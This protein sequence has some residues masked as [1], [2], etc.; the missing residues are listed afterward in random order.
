MVTV[1]EGG[2]YMVETL[3]IMRRKDMFVP[4]SQKMKK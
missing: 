4:S 1:I 2:A 3:H